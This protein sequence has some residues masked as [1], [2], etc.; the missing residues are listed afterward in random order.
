MLGICWNRVDGGEPGVEVGSGS[1]FNEWDESSVGGRVLAHLYKGLVG[2][3][4]LVLAL[5]RLDPGQLDA[6]TGVGTEGLDAGD[7]VGGV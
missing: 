6:G 5:S 2:G 7:V 1:G 4:R 3:D